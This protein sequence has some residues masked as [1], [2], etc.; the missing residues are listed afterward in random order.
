MNDKIKIFHIDTLFNKKNL[1]VLTSFKNFL[2]R[3][4]HDINKC[5]KIRMNNEREDFNDD[6]INY[7]NEKNIWLKFI[8]VENSQ[9]NEIIKRLNQTFMRK[10]NFFFKNNDLHFKW[11]F[12]LINAINHLRNICSITNLINSNKKSIILYKVFIDYSYNYNFFRRIDQRNEY[13]II[14]FNTSYKKFDDH[15]ILSVLINYKNEHIYQVIIES[16][17]FKKCFNVE[18]Y[19]SFN[20]TSFQV[21][22]SSLQTLK[23]FQTFLWKLRVE[24]IWYWLK[25]SNVKINYIHEMRFL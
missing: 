21:S 2:N 25:I 3:I 5:I 24:K 10:A 17:K 23:S 13:Q 15:K 7:I 1:E 8:I 18:W 16:K 20:K 11:W 4:K 9:I 14:K 19:N 6:F 12:E 22:Q